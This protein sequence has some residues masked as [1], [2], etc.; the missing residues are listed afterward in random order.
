M[1]GSYPS[2]L[3]QGSYVPSTYIINS[4]QF[5]DVDVN[6]RQF[7][8]LIVRLTDYVNAINLVLNN[9]ESSFFSME[10]F[11]NSQQ[12]FPSISLSST[13][14]QSPTYR[15]VFRKVINFGA[16]PNTASKSVAHGIT[17]TPGYSFTHIYG[18][19]TN[20]ARTSF[21]PLPYA[22]P[23]L[24][25][26]IEVEVTNANVVITTGSDRTSYT[27]SYIVLEYIKS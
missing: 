21:I 15:Q 25:N 20:T 26:N 27:T 7:K 18:A 11:L 17:I 3:N 2:Q 19:A 4:S 14:A 6:S 8:D 24:A 9:K 16:L 1:A 22:S 13:S 12:F 5:Y 10:E 23:T